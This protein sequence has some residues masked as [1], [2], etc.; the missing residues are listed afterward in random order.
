MAEQEATMED[1]TDLVQTGVLGNPKQGATLSAEFV[2]ENG[3]FEPIIEGFIK[4][5]FTDKNGKV[6]DKWVMIFRDDLPGVVLNATRQA[7]LGGIFG[8]MDAGKIVGHRV[9]VAHDPSVSFGG[10]KVG[11]I[12]L[13]PSGDMNK[14]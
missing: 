1:L 6:E 7:Q 12:K 9:I 3:P 11:G 2:K 8:S 14:Y 10:K 4:R 5:R 13:T